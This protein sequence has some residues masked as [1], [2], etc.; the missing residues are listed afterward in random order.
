MDPG[1]FIA[2]VPPARFRWLLTAPAAPI[3]HDFCS[4]RILGLSRCGIPFDRLELMD[5]RGR[6]MR[7]YVGWIAAG[8][9]G[10]SLISAGVYWRFANPSHSAQSSKVSENPYDSSYYEAL[11]PGSASS[12][13]QILPEVVRLIAPKSAVDLGSG[14]GEWL[15]ELRKLGVIRRHWR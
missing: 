9:F 4:K 10:L 8:L 14:T 1:P 12:A 13:A 5:S 15:G 2:M 11:S 6:N 7:K 3:G